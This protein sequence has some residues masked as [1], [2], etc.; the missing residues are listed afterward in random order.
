[1]YVSGKLLFDKNR[2]YNYSDEGCFGFMWNTARRSN[3]NLGEVLDLKEVHFDVSDTAITRKTLELVS[4]IPVFDIFTVDYCSDDY[5]RTIIIDTTEYKADRIIFTLQFIRNLCDNSIKFDEIASKYNPVV[6]FLFH[7]FSITE[8]F[9]GDYQFNFNYDNDSSVYNPNL[10]TKDDFKRILEHTVDNADQ[11]TNQGTFNEQGGYLKSYMFKG[12]AFCESIG[13][14]YKD[15]VAEGKDP[16]DSWS[17]SNDREFDE[18]PEPY[19]NRRVG[20]MYAWKKN[21]PEYTKIQNMKHLNELKYNATMSSH[22]EYKSIE[23][24][25][26]AFLLHVGV[27]PI[28]FKL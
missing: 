19:N 14:D 24:A 20:M 26:D 12:K 2:V 7:Y 3:S 22:L 1:M 16:W 9:S 5:P 25:M 8:Q 10:L 27:N 15:F 18:Y 17:Y 11:F 6:A 4:K 23:E 13:Q 28:D 21:R